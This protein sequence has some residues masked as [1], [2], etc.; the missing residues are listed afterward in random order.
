M[1]MRA[2][3][4]ALLTVLCVPALAPAQTPATPAPAPPV[5]AKPRPRAPAAA[6]TA[7]LTVTVNDP[8]GA[9]LSDVKVSATGP[10]EREGVTT[11]MGQVRMLAV[12]A[13][14]YRLRFEKDG[15]YTFEKEVVWRARTP[16][17][18]AEATLTPAPP[19]PPPPEPPKP[20]PPPAPEVPDYP[21]GKPANLSVP[22]YIERN[23]ITTKEP[24]KENL[25]GCSGGAQTWLWQVRDPWT[26]R[27]H[28]AAEL[29][30]YVV[31][32]EGTVALGGR[33]VQVE[34]GTYFLIP[35]GT[36]YSLSKRGRAA[37]L[38]LLATLSGPPC[39]Q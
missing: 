6:A 2:M 1:N 17:P 3:A 13:G 19:P 9:P 26:N 7:V 35:R 14:T 34:A 27:S 8:T 38:Y 29:M 39:A 12:R 33:D 4:A 18:T 11:A 37:A 10:V 16:P 28:D 24:H 25:I 20:E 36:T 22:D 15:F 32:G 30:L 21:A 31:G 23:H 5:T